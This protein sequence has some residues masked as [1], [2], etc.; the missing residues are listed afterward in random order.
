METTPWIASLEFN[1]PGLDSMS[2]DISNNEASTYTECKLAV[3]H[4]NTNYDILT[5]C[6]KSRN[7]SANISKK[8]CDIYLCYQTLPKVDR[9]A[10]EVFYRRIKYP[11]YFG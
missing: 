11:Y 4:M 7:R 10:I 9:F 1:G 5:A 8:I 6:L 3:L 2:P